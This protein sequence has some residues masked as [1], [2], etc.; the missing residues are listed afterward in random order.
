M[1]VLNN[2]PS[3]SSWAIATSLSTISS[4]SSA[5][6]SLKTSNSQR[7]PAKLSASKSS[8][9]ESTIPVITPIAATASSGLNDSC[10]IFFE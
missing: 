7:I 10:E 1:A 9:E 4:I 5:E 8:M 6:Y 3:P 2:A